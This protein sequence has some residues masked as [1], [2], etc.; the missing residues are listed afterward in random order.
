MSTNTNALFEFISK[1]S[2][3][4]AGIFYDSL[5]Y[6]GLIFF[7]V[8]ILKFFT[9]YYYFNKY[10]KNLEFS[11][12]LVSRKI[13]KK[14]F[15]LSI[16]PTL[17]I[18]TLLFRH[19]LKILLIGLYFGPQIIAYI[20]TCKTLFYFL[21][22]RIFDSIN[23]ITYYEYA[24]LFAKR[25]FSGLRRFHNTHILLV[26]S[27]LIIFVLLSLS[28][29]KYVYNLW[30]NNQFN[31]TYIFLL[32]VL[33]DAACAVLFHSIINVSI[34]INNYLKIST[35]EFCFIMFS[36]IVSFYF[37]SLGYSFMVYFFIVLLQSFIV[38]LF[39]MF[40]VFKFYKFLKN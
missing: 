21:P 38:L 20:T 3:V 37:L 23:L 18:F 25:K 11:L 30:L 9:F 2:V 14:L 33:L 6:A 40:I 7:I 19:N 17:G 31:L 12:K 22:V 1:L 24:K 39:A 32:V 26:L 16:A 34:A 4:S 35:I 15:T 36:T 13:I 5:I 27:L 8:A 29:G 10:K 28:I